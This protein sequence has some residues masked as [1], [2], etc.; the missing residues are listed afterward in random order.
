MDNLEKHIDE[1]KDHTS[2]KFHNKNVI[3]AFIFL[4]FLA[5][6]LAL[7]FCKPSAAPSNSYQA[8]IVERPKPVNLFSALN[9]PPKLPVFKSGEKFNFTISREVIFTGNMYDANLTFELPEDI[10]NRQK[11][12]NIKVS[13]KPQKIVKRPDGTFATLFFKNPHGKIVIK[14]EGTAQVRTYNLDIAEKINKNID[15]LLTPEEKA[16][17]LCEELRIDTNSRLV[18]NVC[19]DYINTAGNDVDTVK[20]I[21]DYV[22]NHMK[23]SISEINKNKG[24]LKALQSGTGV[25]EEFADLFVTLCRAKGIP[26]RVVQGFDLPFKGEESS[27]AHAWAEVYF[28]KYGWVTFDPT[29]KMNNAFRK[30]IKEL[31]ITPYDALSELIKYRTYLTVDINLLTVKYEGRGNISSRNLGIGYS[32]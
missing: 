1:E 2:K 25:C 30:K 31:Q 8:K 17:Y 18:K 10:P 28:D 5:G 20:N 26:A 29:N 32:K 13:P 11:I 9:I 21:F 14:I 27:T 19:R 15:G 12:L 22:V 6:F 23:Y 3:M 4:V 7:L 24:A 16:K